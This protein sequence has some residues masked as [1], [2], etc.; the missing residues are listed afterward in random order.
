ME[1]H[2]DVRVADAG[3][4]EL[5]LGLW[6]EGRSVRIN[7]A[8]VLERDV[9]APEQGVEADDGQAGQNSELLVQELFGLGE[10]LLVVPDNAQRAADD[11]EL[12]IERVQALSQL[13]A[14]VP[15]LGEGRSE[16]LFVE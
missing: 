10:L 15:Y 1:H 3:H 13:T 11:L 7:R 9:A 16:E 4:D 14:L 2:V 6:R 8:E 12:L 5:F